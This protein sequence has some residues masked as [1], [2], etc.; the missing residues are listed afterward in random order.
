MGDTMKHTGFLALLTAILLLGLPALCFA[1]E[2]AGMAEPALTEAAEGPDEAAGTE[3]T[4][5]AADPADTEGTAP[6]DDPA[7]TAE[8]APAADPA[9]TEE[10]AAAEE[11]GQPSPATPTDLGCLH[12]HIATTVY[13]FDS[14][15]YESI[16]AVS[17]RVSGPAVA[18][19]VCLDCG[20]ILS[21]ETMNEASE[22]RPHSIK[23]GVCALCGYQQ[24]AQSSSVS[25]DAPGERTM[26]AQPDG[27]GLLFLTLT[28]QDL[29][30]LEKAR[31]STLLIRGEAGKAVIAMDVPYFC[32]EVGGE[33]A[34]LSV[35][36]A[37]QEDGSL[38]AAMTMNT[39]P[40][41]AQ[42][43]ESPKGVTLR[44][45]QL[46]EPA[47][48]VIF[49]G[50]GQDVYEPEVTWNNAGFWSVPYQREGSYLL[51]Y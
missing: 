33:Q 29:S 44:F 25:Q 26:M 24:A 51:T 3:E 19:T 35:E 48:R 42:E 13:F 32:S 20:E 21:D 1:E 5:P 15:A 37:E 22:I 28:E 11:A 40:G 50:K 30:A 34:S 36:M 14:P 10:A 27:S 45:Y 18:E 2:A 16:S 49:T 38:Y 6:A 9:A 7:G 43:L 17:H 47:L 8:T 41:R 12:A 23:K 46:P 4:P 31:V 39:A